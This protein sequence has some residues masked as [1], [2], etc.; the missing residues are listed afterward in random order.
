MFRHVCD[1]STA[2]QLGGTG[3][4]DNLIPGCGGCNA[5]KNNSPLEECAHHHPNELFQVDSGAS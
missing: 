3:E 4:R 5:A 1:E 2:D